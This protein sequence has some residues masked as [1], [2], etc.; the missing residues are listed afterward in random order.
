MIQT[1]SKFGMTTMRDY[2]E[3]LIRNNLVDPDYAISKISSNNDD[4][5]RI[6]NQSKY[7]EVK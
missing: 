6:E 1:G 4:I 7:Y 3:K 5:F 2:V